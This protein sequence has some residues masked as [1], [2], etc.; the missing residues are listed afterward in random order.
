MRE[1]SK[2]RRYS[3]PCVQ[4]KE[5][6]GLGKQLHT[7][8]LSALHSGQWSASFHCHFI[9]NERILNY[10]ANKRLGDS[11]TQP[12]WLPL[13]TA[14][15]FNGHISQSLDPE[16][17]KIFCLKKVCINKN[18][19]ANLTH[20]DTDFVFPSK[21]S[22]ICHFDKI[23]G[24]GFLQYQHGVSVTSSVKRLSLTQNSSSVWDKIFI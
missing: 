13:A 8:F 18:T 11:Q 10:P 15:Q 6:W 17:I 20:S 1:I 24:P 19:F 4:K 23:C 9:T 16:S 2:C 3:C 5:T 12:G 22:L 21:P 7:S 14:Q